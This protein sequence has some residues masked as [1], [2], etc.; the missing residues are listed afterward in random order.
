MSLL[1]TTFC[2]Y[3][4]SYHFPLEMVGGV[5]RVGLGGALPAASPTATLSRKLFLV[6]T[7]WLWV[8]LALLP[9]LSFI[10]YYD[11]KVGLAL[12]PQLSFIRYYDL[13]FGLILLPQPY[14]VR[15]YNLPAR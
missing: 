12:L 5:P 7:T 1:G 6:A 4:S 2:R 13:K 15:F 10:R 9:Q 3:A 11:L 8:G 14:F